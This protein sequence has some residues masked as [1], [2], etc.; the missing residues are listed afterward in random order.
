[1]DEFLAALTSIRAPDDTRQRALSRA[2]QLAQHGLHLSPESIDRLLIGREGALLASGRIELGDGILP[3]LIDALAPSPYL[4]QAEL[5]PTLAAMQEAFYYYKSALRETWSDE[6]LLA[7]MTALYNGPA[8]GCIEA[9]T[10]A[11]EALVRREA[12]Q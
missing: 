6:A 11:L 9:V 4:T 12:A 10:D 2:G 7:R 1:M 5:E 8:Q 3:A